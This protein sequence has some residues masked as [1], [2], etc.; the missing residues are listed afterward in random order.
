V[1][2]THDAY[3]LEMPGAGLLGDLRW[4][5]AARR[6]PGRG[7]VEIAVSAVGLNFREVM[8]A[9]GVY[10]GLEPNGAALTFD[11]DVAGTVVAVGEA[12]G[13]LEIGDEV[14][15]L[16]AGTFATHVVLPA[17][18]LV[19]RPVTISPAQ[20]ASL[21]VAG[22][23]AHYA[24]RVLARLRA[25]ERVLIHAA[26]GGVGTAAVMIC[27]HAG[28]EI[29]ATAGNEDKR[30]FLRRLGVRHVMSSRTLDF[31]H[32]VLHATGGGGVD[33]VV[34]SLAGEFITRSL[35]VLA[36]FGRFIEL[37]RRD[38]YDGGTLPLAPFRNNLAFFAVD[39]QQMRPEQ[40]ADLLAQITT[41]LASG[42]LRPLPICEFRSADA[43]RAFQFM[44]RAKHIGKV[45]LVA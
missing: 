10:P 26:A 14:F 43:I 17:L 1:I 23:T 29:F 21:P 7:E 36:P 11:G 24:L 19:R 2:A 41:A 8:K 32:D 12:V 33:V 39:L 28:A 3:R 34:N 6:A 18:M 40:I 30:D 37:G 42:A 22:L 38:I 44:R 16:G 31:A 35:D 4:R 20:A 9:L 5:A 45:V 27:Q 15:G 25:G 13:N